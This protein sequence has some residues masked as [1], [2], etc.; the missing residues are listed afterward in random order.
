MEA[1]Q[2]IV[3]VLVYW[4]HGSYPNSTLFIPLTICLGIVSLLDCNIGAEGHYSA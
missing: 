1:T 2:L 4:K 3:S